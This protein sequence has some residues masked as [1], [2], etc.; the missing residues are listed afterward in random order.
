MANVTVLSTAVETCRLLDSKTSAVRLT[1]VIHHLD[2]S[3]ACDLL[4]SLSHIL[5][6]VE[7]DLRV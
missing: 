2:P 3:A 4:H 6:V 5:L 7:Q 1:S